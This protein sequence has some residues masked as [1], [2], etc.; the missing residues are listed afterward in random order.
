MLTAHGWRRFFLPTLELRPYRE[1]PPAYYWLAD[2]GYAALGVGAGGARAASAVAGWITV[3][4]VYLWAVPRVGAAGALGAGLVAATSAGW[5]G[6]ARYG[7]LDMTF[8]ACVTLGVLAGLAWLDRP[9]PRPPPRAPFVAAALGT[10]VKGPLALVLV[11]GP[12]L[13][14]GVA[15]RPRPTLREL[16]VGR[17]LAIA[18][19]IVALGFGPIAVLDPHTL[20]GFAATNVRRFGAASPHA[21][22]FWSYALWLPALFLPWTVLAIPPLIAAAR[23][24]RRRELLAWAVFVPAVLTLATGKLPTYVLPALPPLA[25]L[26]GPALAEIVQRGPDAGGRRAVRVAGWIGVAAL[27]AFGMLALFA[28]RAYPVGFF[29]SALLAAAALGWGA[30]GIATLRAGRLERVPLVV[31]GALLTL[32]PLGIRTVGPVASALHSD[33]DAATLIREA[34]GGPVI[35]FG[36]WAP[37]LTFYTAAPTLRTDDPQVVRDLFD[38]PGPTFLVT[39]NRHFAEV[40][41]LLGPRA[42]VWHATPRR[43]LYANRPPPG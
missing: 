2:A 29:A 14:A 13:L 15:R 33:H 8:T 38:A 26:V 3:L 5:F 32:Y 10:L 34:G 39:G 40:E 20:L 9:A 37:S 41:N 19:A 27:V 42:H 11:A 30:A 22:P 7:N 1:K 6:L 35:A 12:L 18:G 25:L 28:R 36:A 4:A 17:G 43:R 24:A 23:D 31:L 21:A 16:G